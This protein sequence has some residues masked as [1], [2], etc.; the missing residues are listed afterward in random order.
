[1]Y[2]RFQN[3]FK[4][5][6]IGWLKLVYFNSPSIVFDI[7]GT[8]GF[9][10]TCQTSAKCGPA[11]NGGS[12]SNDISCSGCGGWNT[13]YSAGGL[14]GTFRISDGSWHEVQLHVKLE[15]NSSS[16]DGVYEYWIDGSKKATFTN[17]NFNGGASS[18][19]GSFMLPSNE[20]N[21]S[22]GT[23]MYMDIDDVAMSTSY[24]TPLGGGTLPTPN[25]P[26]NLHFQ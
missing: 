9:R 2:I 23:Y 14:Y 11:M 21:P 3:G 4:W 19:W 26:S 24:I 10:I 17:V 18:G 8:D 20:S 15:T 1:M 22:N 5:A 25:A 12:G 13:M 6:S 7:A 16:N